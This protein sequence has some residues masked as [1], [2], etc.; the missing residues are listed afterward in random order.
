MLARVGI[1][2]DGQG[3][4]C[5]R[6]IG[7]AIKLSD[8][9]IGDY[10]EDVDLYIRN[11]GSEM[12]FVPEDIPYLRKVGEGK[13]APTKD[14]FPFLVGPIDTTVSGEKV[15]EASMGAF[16]QDPFKANWYGCCSPWGNM[17]LFYAWEGTLRYADGV[18]RVNLLLNRA[19]PWM[20]IDSYLPY[21]GKVVLKNKAAREAFVRIPL[22]VDEK[23][24]Q[25]RIGSRKVVPEWFGRYLRLKPLKAG[26]VISIEFPEDERTERW[27]L[28][29]LSYWSVS[30]TRNYRFKGNT[31]IEITPPPPGMHQPEWHLYKS[32]AEKYKQ[33]QA[34]MKKVLRYVT[35]QTL[36]W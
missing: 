35:P 20:D 10:W 28:A 24:V 32:R 2:G 12:Q 26:D 4:G 6:L 15:M 25:C 23:M 21:Q 22:Y 3:C 5:G 31:L 8:T 7:L 11:H 33:A 17:G 36:K 9:G 13:P 16:G 29:P 14:P 34:P 19:S 30:A 1:V 18:A 27:S